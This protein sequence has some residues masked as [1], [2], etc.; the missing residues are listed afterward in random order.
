[1]K[2]ENETYVS[3][4]S[5]RYYGWIHHTV[6]HTLEDNKGEIVR[7]CSRKEYMFERRGGWMP[8]DVLW[9]WV[10]DNVD[11]ERDGCERC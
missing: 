11:W 5:A 1:M 9:S 7:T 4:V 3:G 6:A 2:N 10:R 8:E